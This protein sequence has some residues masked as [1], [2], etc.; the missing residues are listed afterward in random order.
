MAVNIVNDFLKHTLTQIMPYL[1]EAFTYVEASMYAGFRYTYST[2]TAN[3]DPTSGFLK[4]DSATFSSASVFR[5]S[6]T[7]AFGNA[8]AAYLAT[9]DDGASAKR[10]TVIM[11]KEGSETS[12]FIF[13]ITSAITDNGAWV[14]FSISFVASAGAIANN[15]AVRVQFYPL[16]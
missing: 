11:K 13:Q 5:I 3:S 8:L 4:F 10:C 12:F 2:N 1:R 14:Q 15:D 16:T 9:L 7:D 6:E